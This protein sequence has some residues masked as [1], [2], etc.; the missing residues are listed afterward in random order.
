MKMQIDPFGC[1]SLSQ[2][3]RVRF[4]GPIFELEDE[5]DDQTAFRK[6]ESDRFP[7]ADLS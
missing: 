5:C 1:N 6:A 4:L 2:V 3:I 7:L